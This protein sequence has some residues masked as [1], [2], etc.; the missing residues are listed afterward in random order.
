MSTHYGL[1]DSSH[2]YLFKGDVPYRHDGDVFSMQ[3]FCYSP[4]NQA[5]NWTHSLAAQYSLFPL[6]KHKTLA[7]DGIRVPYLEHQLHFEKGR[8]MIAAFRFL[9]TPGLTSAQIQTH[10]RSLETIH[11]YSSQLFLLVYDYVMKIQYEVQ[12]LVSKIKDH[13]MM[14]QQ[15]N[16]V[17]M[18]FNELTS[19]YQPLWQEV[20]SYSRMVYPGRA[21]PDVPSVGIYGSILTKDDMPVGKTYI[22]AYIFP[23]FMEQLPEHIYEEL[24]A[25]CAEH[26]LRGRQ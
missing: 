6:K 1:L 11:L 14:G 13:L 16:T 3:F 10:K 15:L 4:K 23:V 2:G 18:V 21:Y 5:S 8:S 7:T 20:L 9:N 12:H 26:S 25:R 24:C 19:I 22:S 17:Q